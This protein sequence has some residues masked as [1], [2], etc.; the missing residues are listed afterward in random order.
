MVAQQVIAEALRFAQYLS[1]R[2]SG[3]LM[4]IVVSRGSRG[5]SFDSGF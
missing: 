5:R 1:A 4:V 2:V 3:P